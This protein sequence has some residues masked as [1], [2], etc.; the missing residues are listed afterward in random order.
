[1][2]T[3]MTVTYLNL[4]TVT[5]RPRVRMRFNLTPYCPDCRRSFRDKDLHL[6]PMLQDD[7]WLTLA[8]NRHVVLCEPCM[9]AR[10]SHD[11]GSKQV[12][13]IGAQDRRSAI[14]QSVREFSRQSR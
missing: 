11:G 8:G 14:W 7:V 10:A 6:G 9:E 13:G 2:V 1:M 4:T 5:R 3:P 12:I